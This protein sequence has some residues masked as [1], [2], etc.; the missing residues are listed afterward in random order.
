MNKTDIII[1]EQHREI[2]EKIKKICDDKGI[3]HCDLKAGFTVVFEG[4]DE[5]NTTV[6]LTKGGCGNT[7]T[8]KV[9]L[10]GNETTKELDE[11]V[12]FFIYYLEASIANDMQQEYTKMILDETY[13]ATE[14]TE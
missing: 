10:D 5:E 2:E 14:P 9:N 8:M 4:N 13:K 1:Q 6:R 11:L 7:F 3:V 12:E